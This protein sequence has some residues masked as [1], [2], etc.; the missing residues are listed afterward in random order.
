MI[1]A[2]ALAIVSLLGLE[3]IASTELT[4]RA[5]LRPKK[6]LDRSFVWS[7]VRL[8]SKDVTH[9]GYL[10]PTTR[11]LPSTWS[12]L[13]AEPCCVAT[14]MYVFFFTKLSLQSVV[15]YSNHYSMLD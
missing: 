15:N 14:S 12:N 2:C 11:Y 10:F 8:V 4:P 7:D 9:T 3:M 13:K 1:S 5:Q 6:R